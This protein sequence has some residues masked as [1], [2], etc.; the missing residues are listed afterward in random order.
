MHMRTEWHRHIFPS[1]PLDFAHL[2]PSLYQLTRL[3]NWKVAALRLCFAATDEDV[4]FH[5]AAPE[6]DFGPDSDSGADDDVED[7]G[8]DLPELGG[9]NWGE[10]DMPHLLGE[11]GLPE[12]DDD[13]PELIIQTG[14]AP[15]V[16]TWGTPALPALG[17]PNVG[18]ASGGNPSG[19]GGTDTGGGVPF[20]DET[21]SF[22][23]T[24]LCGGS[25]FG[26]LVHLTVQPGRGSFTGEPIVTSAHVQPVWCCSRLTLIA[27]SLSL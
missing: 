21:I 14:P 3:R 18:A 2:S 5:D 15:A 7:D 19:H 11:D 25:V 12:V 27:R 6:V 9:N 10:D 23:L 8:G 13:V 17:G 20:F 26:S 1:V 24:V 22:G 4:N 16:L